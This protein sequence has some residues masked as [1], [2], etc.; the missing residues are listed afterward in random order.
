MNTSPGTLGNNTKVILDSVDFS[1]SLN[2]VKINFKQAIIDISTFGAYW[3]Q[4]IT[5]L[6][7]G[8]LNYT[9][10]FDKAL[11]GIDAKLFAMLNTAS[12]LATALAFEVEVPNNGASGDVRYT[13]QVLLSDYPITSDCK[14]AVK[15][16]AAFTLTGVP[17]RAITAS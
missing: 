2:Q 11:A 6:A 1:G 14:D 15:I 8:T 5:G 7:E 9:G 16:T 13:G 17:T 3:K 4:H 12:A 10:F